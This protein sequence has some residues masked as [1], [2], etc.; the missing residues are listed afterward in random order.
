[1]SLLCI[2]VV[3][4]IVDVIELVNVTKRDGTRLLGK[5]LSWTSLA[6]DY[7]SKPLPAN[8]FQDKELS[9]AYD[10][11]IKSEAATRDP[12]ELICIRVLGFLMF[13]APT[14]EGKRYVAREILSSTSKRDDEMPES[15]NN[16]SI[17]K[18][19]DLG[20]YFALYFIR[21]CE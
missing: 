13:H 9:T 16:A 20:W 6:M 21:F 7:E 19:V 10:L 3:S 12:E 5:S 8:S 4:F 14:D 2:R 15:C 18:L 17:T 1:M 11:C